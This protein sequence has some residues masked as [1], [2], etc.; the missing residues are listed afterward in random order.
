MRIKLPSIYMFPNYTDT[1]A[2]NLSHIKDFAF[3]YSLFLQLEISLAPW[4][5]VCGGSS[6]MLTTELVA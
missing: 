2:E 6:S 1:R 3:L 4:C 5:D